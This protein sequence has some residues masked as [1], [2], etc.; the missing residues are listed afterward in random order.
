M[1]FKQNQIKM[2]KHFMDIRGL[3]A[4]RVKNY[5]A[6]DRKSILGFINTS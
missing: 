4:K 3:F 2:C 1:S 5:Q 6:N